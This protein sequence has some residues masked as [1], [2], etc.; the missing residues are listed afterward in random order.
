MPQYQGV[1]LESL[2]VLRILFGFFPTY[3]QVTT[4][5]FL[6]QPSSNPWI[7]ALLCTRSCILPVGL[8][9]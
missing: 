6:R 2:E 3:R 8:F 9:K 1:E 4:C 5:N 7:A